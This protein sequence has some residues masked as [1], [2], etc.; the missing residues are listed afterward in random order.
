MFGHFDSRFTFGSVGRVSQ[1]EQRPQ[2]RIHFPS[3]YSGGVVDI[4][5]TPRPHDRCWRDQATW[6]IAHECVHL[7]DP[8]EEGKANYLEE[9]LATWFQME[10]RFH[11]KIVK[12]YLKKNRGRL[13]RDPRYVTALGMVRRN[14]PGLK[15]AI[16]DIRGSGTRALRDYAEP[17]SVPFGRCGREGAHSTLRAFPRLLGSRARCEA[18]NKDKR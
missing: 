12:G 2:P 6:Q 4:L 17:P 18:M 1:E 9:G 16:R 10:P 3:C 11:N 13:I 14:M 5:I 15:K 8:C 7:L